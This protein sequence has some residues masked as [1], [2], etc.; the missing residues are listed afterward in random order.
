MCWNSDGTA[1]KSLI[2]V[3]DYHIRIHKQKKTY[4]DNRPRYQNM[5]NMT[6]FKPFVPNKK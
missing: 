3:S 6:L 1:P 2:K 4:A 5:N